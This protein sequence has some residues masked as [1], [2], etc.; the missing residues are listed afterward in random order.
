MLGILAGIGI[1][2]LALDDFRI[3]KACFLFAATWAVGGIVMWGINTMRSTGFRLSIVGIS[4]AIIGILAVESLRYVDR[5]REAKLPKQQKTDQQNIKVPVFG[6]DIGLRL[7]SINRTTGK[8]NIYLEA[9]ITNPSG[10]PSAIL[11]WN[12][13]IKFPDGHV[14]NGQI[15]PTLPKDN[16]IIQFNNKTRVTMKAIDYL[17]H[18]GVATIPSGGVLGGWI[19]ASFINKDIDEAYEN[20]AYI[21]LE[22]YDVIAKNENY[23]TIPIGKKVIDIPDNVFWKD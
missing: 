4:F 19:C 16:I 14:V 2:V 9:M 15:N 3:A 13:A 6:G 23:L 22:F 7:V 21:V 8:S 11:K 5:K 1:G 12:I 10:P 20:H 17:P 18:K